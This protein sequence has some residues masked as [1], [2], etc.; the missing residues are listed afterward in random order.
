MWFIAVIWLTSNV[1]WFRLIIHDATGATAEIDIISINND[2]ARH[3]YDFL[4]FSI[5]TYTWRVVRF[6]KFAVMRKFCQSLQT[7][8]DWVGSA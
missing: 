2:I 6:A 8:Q 7:R 1:D 5:Y 4:V 3:Y